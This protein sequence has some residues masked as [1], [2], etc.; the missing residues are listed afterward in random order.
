MPFS[1]YLFV[2]NFIR[3]FLFNFQHHQLSFLLIRSICV[4]WN[5]FKS[6]FIAQ[7]QR[8]YTLDCTMT[9]RKWQFFF[10]FLSIYI[11]II[12]VC[13]RQWMKEKWRKKW[14]FCIVFIVQKKKLKA[15]DSVEMWWN[16]MG[17]YNKTL[18]VCV[19]MMSWAERK[20]NEI[21]VHLFTFQ[22]AIKI[23]F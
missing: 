1:L 10:V 16:M 14:Y 22:S 4:Q 20:I 5:P 12:T 18:F 8:N 9:L 2:L 15:I 21:A 13:D 17:H 23:L 3:N 19:S 7:K 6:W 11:I